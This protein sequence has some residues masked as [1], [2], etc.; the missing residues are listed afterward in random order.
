MSATALAQAGTPARELSGAE[1]AIATVAL[2][3]GSFMN[4]LDL[5]IANVSVP[6]ISGDLGVSYTVGTWV[7]TSY[8]V[9]EAIMLPLTGWL[10]QRFGQVRMFVMAT[11]L[12]TLA[13][14]MCG[15]SPSFPVLLAARVMQ[16]VVGASMIPLSQTLLTGLYPP[17]KRG[18]ALGLW[19]M[20]T[21][22][23]PI[24]GPLAGGWL[25]EA[26]SW[27]WVFLINLPFGLMV[28]GVVWTLLGQRDTPRIKRPVDRMGLVLLAIGVG[29]L[30]ILLDKGN[31]LDWF[32]SGEV[33]GLACIAVVALSFFVVWELT[34]EHPVV[35]LHLFAR[36]NF[37][38]GAV[39]L[40]LGSMAFFGTVVLIPLWLQAFQ[41]YTPLW[42][43]KVVAF[44]GVFAVMLGPV[45]GSNIHRVDARAIATF[46]FTT[47]ALVAFWSTRFTPDVDYWTVATAR[48]LMGIGISCF[49]LPLVTINLSG[50]LPTQIAAATGL[51]NFMRNLGSSFGTAIMVS[52]WDHRTIAHHA[53]LA[54][55]VTPY[56]APAR[57]YLAQLHA[58]G[59]SDTQAWG[60]IEHTITAQSSLM[61]T[62]DVLLVCGL[63]MLCLIGPIW[64]TRPPFTVRAGS[65][66]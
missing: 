40:M 8:A 60:Q 2:G 22:L 34:A 53:D 24:V 42:A 3:F 36:R 1:R 55:R 16:G 66:H 30:Q 9:S 57:D 65:D 61:A 54:E 39:C 32:G 44:G 27:H 10:A 12:F 11:L 18:M 29:A 47:F 51:S 26:L 52:L 20:T 6:A 17:Q 7:I 63:I 48:L 21:I 64:L 50:L 35:E 33:I 23:A 5:S 4:I 41:G 56:D 19:S 58:L 38:I 28:A 25:T 13:S 46:G 31:E 14:M 59:L 37:A 62:N 45:V 49:F 43:G 15:F